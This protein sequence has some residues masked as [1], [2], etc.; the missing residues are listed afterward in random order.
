MEP[1]TAAQSIPPKRRTSLGA[2][3]ALIIG[4]VLFAAIFVYRQQLIDW[5]MLRGYTAPTEV[6]NIADD[7]TFTDTARRIFYVNKPQILDS[8]HF[9]SKCEDRGK[10][11]TIV[12][13][14]YHSNQLGIY[15]FRVT[16]SRLKGVEQVTAAH[17]LLHAVYDRLSSGDRKQINALLEDYYANDLT[18][19][20]IKDTIQSYRE[21][22]PEKDLV[23]EMHSIFGTEIAVLPDELERYYGQYFTDRQTVVSY[24]AA[25]Q[26]EFTSRKEKVA[27]YDKQLVELKKQIDAEQATL[28]MQNER[29]IG[30][31]A[32]L[33]SLLDSGNTAEYNSR[34]PIFN[35]HVAEYNASV[36]A[37]K[38]LVTSHNAIVDTR[39]A[40]ALEQEELSKAIDSHIESL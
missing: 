1:Q 9:N 13:G 4:L 2:I 5:W 38:A 37:L 20:R 10:E 25:Y 23:N 6:S 17:E 27:A 39:N 22:I 36:E 30:E 8:K 35:Q 11:K 29:L 12:L 31:R 15:L 18:D 33:N 14:C 34:V 3:I 21:T 32:E 28:T 40:T 24:A 19:Q 26:A 7:V 16:D